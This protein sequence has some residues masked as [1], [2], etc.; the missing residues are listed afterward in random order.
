VEARILQCSRPADSLSGMDA[1]PVALK[2]AALPSFDI[3]EELVSLKAEVKHE[4]GV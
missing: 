2:E 3:V 1:I 4:L